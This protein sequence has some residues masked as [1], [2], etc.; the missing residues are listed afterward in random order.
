VPD[1]S[2]DAFVARDEQSQRGL[3]HPLPK[4]R[5]VD[6]VPYLQE[7]AAG[8]RVVHV[9][10]A[11]AGYRQFH[12]AQEEWLHA[13]LAAAA[14]EL[15]GV[16]LD[17]E[18]VEAAR[19]DGYEAHAPDCCDP[20]AVAALSLAPAEVV[21]AGEIIEHLDNPGGFLDALHLLT[22]PDGRLVLTTPNAYGWVNPVAALANIEVNHP[23]HI[24][25]YTWRTL[26]EMLRRHGWEVVETATYVPSVKS[27][28]GEGLKLRVLGLGA[29]LLLAVQRLVART[30]APFVAD[31]LIVV[32]R[33]ARDR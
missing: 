25:M 9:G 23:D 1:R 20:V 8:R 10:F 13:H 26:S 7:Q 16:D 4:A 21:V 12:Q 22:G 27:L 15:V 5:L 3:L 24:V 28:Q 19:A 2:A 11:D 6:R 29:R 32:A 30:V 14:R 17:V 33:P 31:G 18:G